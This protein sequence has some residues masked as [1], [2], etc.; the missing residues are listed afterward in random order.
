MC[1]MTESAAVK[2]KYG[3]VLAEDAKPRRPGQPLTWKERA[4]SERE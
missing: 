1:W 4:L 3:S 2:K